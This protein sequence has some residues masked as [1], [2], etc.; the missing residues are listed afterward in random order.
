MNKKEVVNQL[1][2]LGIKVTKCVEQTA[3]SARA[4]LTEYQIDHDLD[5]VNLG[6]V[7]DAGKKKVVN[8]FKD[9]MDG[10]K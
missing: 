7:V 1:V 8:L 4:R 2:K 5:N 3:G 9:V 6:D 10:L